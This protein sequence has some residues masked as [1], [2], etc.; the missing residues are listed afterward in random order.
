MLKIYNEESLMSKTE[1]KKVI[2]EIKNETI[3]LED[4]E[5][6]AKFLKAAGKE[7]III[8]EESGIV[9]YYEGGE[10][11]NCDTDMGIQNVLDD[12]AEE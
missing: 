8:D 9:F 3:D 1:F 6:I 7:D 5:K 12:I 2:K 10:F 4:T 11:Y